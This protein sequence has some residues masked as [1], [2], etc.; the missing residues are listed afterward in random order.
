MRHLGRIDIQ[1]Q[2]ADL[3]GYGH[4]RNDFNDIWL[5]RRERGNAA[6]DR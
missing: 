1:A 4:Q 2:S 3:I 5:G 6:Y